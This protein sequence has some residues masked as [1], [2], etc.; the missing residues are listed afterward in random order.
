MSPASS[1]T[2]LPPSPSAEPPV[3]L[4]H[5]APVAAV[6]RESEMKGSAGAGANQ[7]TGKELQPED[8]GVQRRQRE[9]E[10]LERENKA[11]EHAVR[12]AERKMA[13]KA[14]A[15][16]GG[17]SSTGEAGDRE[18]GAGE[19]R[20]AEQDSKPWVKNKCRMNPAAAVSPDRNLLRR[21]LVWF[22]GCGYEGVVGTFVC[23]GPNAGG[24]FCLSWD[25]GA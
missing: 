18:A 1:L 16:S 5:A 4:P 20:T 25:D 21:V 14:N 2:P 24:V 8:S 9:V 13:L 17:R 7:G 12:V 11:R 15:G 22:V 19:K 23:Y 6:E 10:L 3:P